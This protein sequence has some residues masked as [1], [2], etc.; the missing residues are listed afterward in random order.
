MSIQTV[1]RRTLY[2]AFGFRSVSC[3]PFA[4]LACLAR[5][6]ATFPDQRGKG[7]HAGPGLRQMS[8]SIRSAYTVV[9]RS[10]GSPVIELHVRL[11]VRVVSLPAGMSSANAEQSLAQY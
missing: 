1:P 6:P 4:A 10:A 9:A 5:T 8:P 7:R 3:T 2:T 11:S